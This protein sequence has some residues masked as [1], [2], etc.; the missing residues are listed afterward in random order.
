MPGL[1]GVLEPG[2]EGHRLK[3]GVGVQGGALAGIAPE[4]GGLSLGVVGHLEIVK[5]L[6]VDV[7]AAEKSKHKTMATEIE[8]R[9]LSQSLVRLTLR[10]CEL[11]CIVRYKKSYSPAG[12]KKA[13]KFKPHSP[14]SGSERDS[15]I[16][17]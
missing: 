10:V 6:D 8:M 14:T 9:L 12:R 16:S 2:V 5:A 17:Y 4:E 3:L 15:V 1:V 7:A 13:V 11:F